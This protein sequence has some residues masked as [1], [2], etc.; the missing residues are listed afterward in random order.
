L[1]NDIVDLLIKDCLAK[2]KMGFVICAGGNGFR[3]VYKHCPFY[4]KESISFMTPVALYGAFI[5]F[6]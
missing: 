1:F 5:C 3:L 2:R 6:R 4:L